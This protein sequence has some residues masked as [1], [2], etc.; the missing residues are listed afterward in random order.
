VLLFLGENPQGREEGNVPVAEGVFLCS[1]VQREKEGG[2]EGASNLGWGGNRKKK[3]P[4]RRVGTGRVVLTGR[5]TGGEI[6]SRHGAGQ[7][8]GGGEEKR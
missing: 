1:G 4:Q 8:E 7:E 5:K 2:E 6:R 3:S